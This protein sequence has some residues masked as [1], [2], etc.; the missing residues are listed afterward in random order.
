VCGLGFAFNDF[1]LNIN[2]ITLK[3]M[4]WWIV[5]LGF[6]IGTWIG[7]YIGLPIK[8][9]WSSLDKIVLYKRENE[10]EIKVEQD[11]VKCNKNC[12]D[13]NESVFKNYNCLCPEC[14]SKRESENKH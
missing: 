4:F 10:P 14:Y 6:T 3:D 13:I 12:S 9:I 7:Y 1:K 2:E 8:Y 5:L 11:C